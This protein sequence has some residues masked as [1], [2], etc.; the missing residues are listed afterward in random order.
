MHEVKT[1][2]G[3]Q[4][5]VER[6]IFQSEDPVLEIKWKGYKVWLSPNNIKGKT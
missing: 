1:T 5:S 6:V 2:F 4:R 3:I